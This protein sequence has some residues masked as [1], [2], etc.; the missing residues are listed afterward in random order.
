VLSVVQRLINENH[1]LPILQVLIYPWL[2]SIQFNSPSYVKN[3]KT[4]CFRIDGTRCILWSLGIRNITREMEDALKKGLHLLLI[5][6][7]NLRSKYMSYLN[8]NL[9]P[10]S[11][12]NDEKYENLKP[13]L[14]S[15]ENLSERNILKRDKNFAQVALKLFDKEIS[16]ALMD[17]DILK[18]LPESYFIIAESDE[19]KDENFVFT[20]RLKNN[21]V[22]NVTISYC[23]H[24]YHGMI[25]DISEGYL[26]TNSVK[27][28]EEMVEFIKR[29]C[30]MS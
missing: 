7:D 13:L 10:D 18:K 24:G 29:K 17:D 12:K 20:E 8:T 16:P 2:Q 26:N 28:V 6:D 21:N 19:F 27:L 5:E 3:R 9:M 25:T 14:P 1:K 23:E 22:N 15:I 11:Y 4:S 30:E